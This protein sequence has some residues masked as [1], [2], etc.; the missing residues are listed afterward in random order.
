MIINT[1]YQGNTSLDYKFKKGNSVSQANINPSFK[2]ATSII[3]EADRVIIDILSQHYG[4]IAKRI[5]EKLYKLTYESDIIRESSRFSEE[6]GTLS[7]K[8]KNIGRSLVENIVFPFV[9]LPLY[10]ISAFLK[11]AQKVSFLRDVATRLYNKP[12]LRIP[13]KLNEV[14]GKTDMLKGMF[15]KTK[16]TL[17]KFAKD[18][19]MTSE[20]LLKILS[21]PDKYPEKKALIEEANNFIKEELYKVSNKFFDKNTGN[22]NTAYERPLNRIITGAIPIYF[23]GSDAYNLAVLCGDSKE[24]SEREAHEREKQEIIRIITTAYIQLLTFGAFTKQVNTISWFAP[25]V[26]GVTVFVSEIFS[27][28]KLDRPVFFLSKDSAQEYNE[29]HPSP[30]IKKTVKNK[31]IQTRNKEN[32]TN[33]LKGFDK[34]TGSNLEF[35]TNT[36]NKTN[37]PKEEKKKALMN[38]DTFKKAVG[39]LTGTFFVLSFIK[40]SS[41]TKNSTIVKSITDACKSIKKNIYEK[42]AKQDFE[43]SVEQYEKIIKSLK[44]CEVD[45]T[46]GCEKI[47]QGHEF[48]KNKYAKIENGKIKMYKATLDSKGTKKAI[49]SVLE[50]I[51]AINPNLNKTELESIRNAIKEAVKFCS[52]D[53]AEKKYYNVAKKAIGI[54][55]NKK[56]N[57][58]GKDKDVQETIIKAIDKNAKEN[59]IKIDT[60]IKPFVDIVVEPFKFIFS[61][62]RLPFKLTKSLINLLVKPIQ[63][64]AKEEALGKADLKGWERTINKIMTEIFGE[65]KEKSRKISQTVF[66]NAMEQLEKKTLPFRK[67][68]EAYEE[69]IKTGKSKNEIDKLKKILDKEQ[70]ELM[71]Y[72]HTAVE[73]SFNGVT[74]SSNKNTDLALM[75]KLVSSSVTTAFLVADNYNMVMIKSNGEDTEEAKEKANE[76]IIQRLSGLFYQ[77]M[78]I[79]WFNATFRST[80]NSSLMGMTAVAIPNT[81]TTEILTRES[82]G[83][84]IRRKTLEEINEIDRK[85]ENR[86]GISGEYFKFMRLLT[87]KKPLKDRL[88]KNKQQNSPTERSGNWSVEVVNNNNPKRRKEKN[89]TN[90]LQTL[91]VK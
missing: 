38:F 8:D 29:K 23:L 74:Q 13:R 84:P 72:V 19:G 2:G 31:E 22:F 66:A 40:N 17:D 67:A 12:I 14:D 80:Y 64:K 6:N 3:P 57:I 53:I 77:A 35:I 59:A 82:I 75:S 37:K 76:R 18:K 68:K 86:K 28:K 89:S 41:Y 91:A 39:I 44:D 60:K 71:V 54:I 11:Q 27:R 34:V 70:N 15:E 55:N 69:A 90:I 21:H 65:E 47:A 52:S 20:E 1:P 62:A 24:D 45:K 51:K 63:K 10:A 49:D 33:V 5:G 87:G 36:D 26:S 43:I 46:S 83:M 85:N 25:A 81:L 73:K 56:I 9:L 7:I 30:N 78:F 79:N 58:K 48:I 16:E 50:N 42:L 32:K 61:A 88:P 4:D